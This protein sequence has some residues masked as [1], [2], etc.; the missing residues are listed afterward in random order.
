MQQHIIVMILLVVVFIFGKE[1]GRDAH[2]R[3][4][5]K[6]QKEAAAKLPRAK[7]VSGF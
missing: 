7:R 6:K 4:L 3:N 1:Y 2:Y 5:R